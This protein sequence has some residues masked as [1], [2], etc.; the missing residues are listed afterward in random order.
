MY[1]SPLVD[2]V[3]Y[4]RNDQLRQA[5]GMASMMYWF[6]ESDKI[7][8]FN[9]NM[10]HNKEGRKDQLVTRDEFGDLMRHNNKFTPYGNSILMFSK[11][12][13]TRVSVSSSSP[14]TKG[15]GLYTLASSDFSGVS[16]MIWN[17][18]GVNN[19]GYKV[20]VNFSNLPS[21]FK[22]KN[23]RVKIYRIDSRTS[24]YHANLEKANLQLVEEKIYEPAKSYS[25]Q[26]ERIKITNN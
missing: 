7:Y 9:W 11:M 17:F 3:G 16:A 20:S 23:L 13:K 15:K 12:K 1:P 25:T 4:M 22:S 21:S 10:R 19:T 6:L 14:I 8:P 24:N 5:A 2:D 26:V 18:Q